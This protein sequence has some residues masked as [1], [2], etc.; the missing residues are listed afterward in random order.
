MATAGGRLRRGRHGPSGEAVHGGDG[1]AGAE[2]RREDVQAEAGGT[3]TTE[4][5]AYTD[6]VG[7]LVGRKQLRG[8]VE[9]GK[10]M[11]AGETKKEENEKC[12]AGNESA[13]ET[14]VSRKV[15]KRKKDNV[16]GAGAP[17]AKEQRQGD[18]ELGRDG[19]AERAIRCGLGR[20]GKDV[21]WEK[22]RREEISR[23]GLEQ[24]RRQEEEPVG[25]TSRGRD[26]KRDHEA[27][28]A[29]EEEEGEGRWRWYAGPAP[30]PTAHHRPLQ[31]VPRPSPGHHPCSPAPG[32]ARLR[33]TPTRGLFH[34]HVW[35]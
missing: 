10:D 23:C 1:D 35:A 30:A 14:V 3:S 24:G 28:K 8:N 18:G 4:Q 29:P 11:W 32:S 17:E 31:T 15:K 33:P 21:R 5:L 19:R 20:L 34:A 26:R 16:G 25:A 22:R 12:G 6:K 7:E 2:S 9:E 27:T 13:S